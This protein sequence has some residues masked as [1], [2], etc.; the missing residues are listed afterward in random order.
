MPVSLLGYIPIWSI[1]S[2]WPIGS[3]PRWG[4]SQCCSCGQVP[5]WTCFWTITV[6]PRSVISPVL[7]LPFLS[8]LE[9]TME[10]RLWPGTIWL[11]WGAAH[12][13]AT[14]KSTRTQA[15]GNQACRQA[16]HCHNLPYLLT[17]L[18]ASFHSPLCPFYKLLC[19][20]LK[21]SLG[22]GEWNQN[23]TLPTCLPAP[24][25]FLPKG[26]LEG[27][28]SDEYLKT[29]ASTSWQIMIFNCNC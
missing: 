5:P 21:V 11:K 24:S 29:R 10:A 16:H 7:P 13:G 15:W 12:W 6:I 23:K 14:A 22:P 27:S 1:F 9:T 19:S 3:F 20:F 25:Q 18:A 4:Y 8:L 17:S 2:K 26:L 28:Q